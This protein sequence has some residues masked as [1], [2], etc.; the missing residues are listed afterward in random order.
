M[1]RGATDDA[2]LARLYF[3]GDWESFE[4]GVRTFA[5]DWVSFRE[6][7]KANAATGLAVCDYLKELSA[8]KRAPLG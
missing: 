6:L 1:I 5:G 3:T 4:K 8:D 2:T 7:R